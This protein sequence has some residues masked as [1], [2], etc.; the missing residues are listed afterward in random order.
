MSNRAQLSKAV[1]AACSR[2]CRLQSNTLGV[3]AVLSVLAGAA[4]AQQPVEEVT[5]TGSRLRRDGMSTPTPVTAVQ[6]DEI[7]AMAP[8]LLM[9]AITQLPQFRDNDTSQTGTIFTT[10]GSNSVNLRGVGSNR[11]LTLL[12]GRRMV[13]GQQTG[14]VD[15]AMIPT[16]LI[17]RVEVV[18]G[19]AS[20][21]YGS[22]A[23]SG[24][25]NFILNTDFEGFRGTVQSGQ[26]SRRDHDSRQ[27]E[28]A[29]GTPIGE[30]GHLI[31]SFD[32]Y[33]VDGVYGLHERGWGQQAWALITEPAGTVPRR[34]YSPN[35]ASRMI[36]TG[37]IIPSGPLAG[38]QFIDGE[39]VPLSEGEV[40][41]TVMIG[42]GNP[43]PGLNWQSLAPDD[44]RSSV[45]AHYKHEVGDDK[46]VF[47]QALRGRHSVTSTPQ[48]LGFAPAWSTEIFVDNPFLPESVRQR[49]IDLGLESVPFNRLYEQFA[50]T[51]RV[52]DDTTSITVG[53]EGTVGSKFFL[54][55][56]YQWGENIEYADYNENYQLPRT[57]RF[58][59]ALDSAIDPDTG[60]IACRANIPAFGGLTAEEEAQVSRFSAAQ[61]MEI[62]ADPLSNT[63]CIP[64]N[65]FG[66]AL[67]QE[68][69]DYIAGSGAYHRMKLRQDVFDVTLQTTLGENRASGPITLGGG[70][71]YRDEWMYQYASGTERDP[72]N[73]PGFG[74]FSSFV[75]PADRIPIRGM[76]TFVRDRPLFYSGNP[77]SQ[78]PISG[79]YDVWEVFVESI[80][81]I[82]GSVGGGGGVDLHLATRYADY[83]GSGGVWAGKAGLDWQAT[84]SVRL[85][86]TWSRDTRAGTLSER[87]DTQT[88]GTGIAAGEDPLVPDAPAYVAE[89]TTGGN[90]NIRPEIADTTTFGVVYQPTWAQNLNM[91]IDFYDIQID[92]AIDQLGTQEILD[93]CYIQGAQDICALITRV[94]ADPPLIRNIFNVYINVAKATTRGADFE[95]SY[96]RPITLVGGNDESI[97]FRFFA[98]YLDEVSFAFTGVG[99]VN[100]AGELEYPEWLA[101][102][103]FTYN[104]GPFSMTWQTRYRDA[105]V[106][107]VLWVDGVDIADNRVPSRT[108]TN[109]NLSYDFALGD[110]DARAY[111]YIGNLFDK[112]PPMVAGGVG[113]TTGWANY[114]NNGIFDVLGRTYAVGFQLGQ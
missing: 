73:L 83:E 64:F 75:D 68:V 3:V 71:A 85:R 103:S 60:R 35:V 23:I 1:R 56:Y 101:T 22:D 113:G 106:R 93:R 16:A 86:A 91:S 95:L 41:G 89:L 14:T 4:E 61:G 65:P 114:T 76:P 34:F 59:R 8:T 5:V 40:H 26:T 100:H 104:R 48:P 45:F 28:V 43:D 79:E 46:T 38:T 105:T 7:R 49:M 39:A 36:T 32:H 58:Y 27:I 66:K 11:T 51:R 18:T 82:L 13:S 88:G 77:N 15:I 112:D 31:G 102:G 72:R 111:F 25:T 80:V 97:A 6:R 74:V 44:T 92:D 94:D 57:D 9:D 78:G 53:F 98:N 30:N 20:A 55:A 37:G 2:G 42:G 90:P 108:Y 87:F 33:T 21:A 63:L 17:D 84:E 109:L 81:P 69:V 12:N 107:N 110:M 10:G 54:T 67:P 47:V 24:V 70:F 19:G 29:V 96:A 52:D 62:F 99:R 50:A